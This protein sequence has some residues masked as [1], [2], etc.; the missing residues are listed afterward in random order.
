MIKNK[1]NKVYRF[2]SLNL[3]IISLDN[4]DF[5][6]SKPGSLIKIGDKSYIFKN[7]VMDNVKNIDKCTAYPDS[8][9]MEY[10]DDDLFNKVVNFNL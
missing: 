8:F 6:Y 7:I 4:P 5:K 9:S 2:K 3:V 10:T 1:I